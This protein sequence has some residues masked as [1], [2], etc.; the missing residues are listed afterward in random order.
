MNSNA[1]FF[2]RYPNTKAQILIISTWILVTLTVLAVNIGRR[3]SLSLRMSQYQMDSLK[4]RYLAKAKL[5]AVIVET[6]KGNWIDQ[7]DESGNVKS[8]DETSKININTAPKYLIIS[9]LKEAGIALTQQEEIS[10]YIIKWRNEHLLR[11]T[12]EL[13]VVLESF[14]NKE[15]SQIYSKIKDFLTVY[16]TN[17]INI[18]TADEKMLNII[19]QAHA[20]NEDQRQAASRVAA[21]IIQLREKQEKKLFKDIDNIKTEAMVGSP[22][23]TLLNKIKQD[24]TLKTNYFKVESDAKV[25]QVR[26]KLTAIYDIAADRIIRLNEL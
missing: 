18:N 17:K 15:A 22:D 1:R 5:N 6:Q 9:L 19:A 11:N 3:V 13:L 24:F 8:E 20:D 25:N 12:E 2:S 16:G 4:A 10:D 14:S 26:K 21:E 23:E 7:T